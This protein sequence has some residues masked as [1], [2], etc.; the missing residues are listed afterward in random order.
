MITSSTKVPKRSIRLHYEL[1]TL[2]YRMLWG[3]HVHHGLF[4]PDDDKCLTAPPGPAQRKLTEHLAQAATIR[5]NETV[6]DVGCGMGGSSILLARDW[7]SH[8][9]GL[10]LSGLQRRW[11]QAAAWRQHVRQQTN[12]R[13]ADAEQ[14][15]FPPECFDIVWSIECT[16]HLQDKQAFFARAAGW[17]KPGGRIAICAWLAGDEPQSPAAH[18]QVQLV[19]DAFLCPSLGTEAEYRRWLTEPGLQLI[20]VNDLTDRVKQTWD[21][22]QRRIQR[23]GMP[24]L[25]RI[26]GREMKQFVDHFMTIRTAYET[27]AMKYAS[28]VATRQQPCVQ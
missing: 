3:E 2:F 11:A 13:R 19:C 5:P 21:I 18:A 12:F 14:V 25:A 9:T 6:L 23:T 26:F 16:E 28:F 27:G 8:V 22:C 10:T 20:H 17:L 4:D 1:A 15:D 24:I 7:Q